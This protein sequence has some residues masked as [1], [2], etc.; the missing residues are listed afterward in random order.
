[1][2]MGE[3]TDYGIVTVLWADQVRGFQVLG[4]DGSWND[5][6]PVYGAL[7]VNFG[8]LTMRLTNEQWLSTL[9]RVKPSVVDGTI[10]RRR[11]AASSTTGTPTPSSGRWRR[12]STMAT[13]RSTP[14]CPSTSTSAP[15]WPVRGPAC[16]T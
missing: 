4:T 9:H 10:Q 11:S 14:P 3:H 1:M 8:D 12:T 7:L 5:V 13:R 2:R 15:S 6:S 16:S